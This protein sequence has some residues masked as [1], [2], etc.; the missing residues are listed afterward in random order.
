ML[1]NKNRVTGSKNFLDFEFRTRFFFFRLTLHLLAHCTF[2]IGPFFANWLL[3]SK[4][5]LFDK[6][7]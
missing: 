3:I 7:F 1:L 4:K 2:S 6:I 5:C